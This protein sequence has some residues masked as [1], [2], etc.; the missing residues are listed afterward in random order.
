[1][2]CWQRNLGIWMGI[3]A[4]AALTACI[5]DRAMD[6]KGQHTLSGEWRVIQIGTESVPADADV[7][8]IFTESRVSG[9]SGCN[10]YNATITRDAVKGVR[11]GPLM[12]TRMACA[13]SLMA[14]EQAFAAALSST[15]AF[16]QTNDATLTLLAAGKAVI[17]AHS[18]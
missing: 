16:D 1:M 5:G 9:A 4:L 15:T 14:L 12:M 17:L 3:L 18:Q 8:M 2:K 11:F 6:R 10:R 7:S 13:P